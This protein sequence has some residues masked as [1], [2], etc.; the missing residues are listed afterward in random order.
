VSSNI[1]HQ[2]WYQL[3]QG[4]KQKSISA[5][6]HEVHEHHDCATQFYSSVMWGRAIQHFIISAEG[7]M[8]ASVI[9]QLLKYNR[10]IHCLHVSNTADG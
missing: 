10:G 3:A 8:N 1:S 9:S 2:V 7:Q 5:N 6:E 4:V